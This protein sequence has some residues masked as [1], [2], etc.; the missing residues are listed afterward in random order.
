MQFWYIGIWDGLPSPR[1]V[2]PITVFSSQYGKPVAGTGHAGETLF[3]G[4]ADLPCNTSNH[5]WAKR[6]SPPES[7][8]PKLAS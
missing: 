7:F 5:A 8:N 1:P 2:I 4:L 3:Q 6:M